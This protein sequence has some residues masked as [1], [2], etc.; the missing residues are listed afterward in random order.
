MS[1]IFTEPLV[2]TSVVLFGGQP[3]N[4][5]WLVGGGVGGGVHPTASFISFGETS[6]QLA[7]LYFHSHRTIESLK[8]KPFFSALLSFE[9]I[10]VPVGF[11]F[12]KKEGANFGFV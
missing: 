11:G 10:F 4:S 9:C 12:K 8:P 3:G 6:K 5:H 2:E 1:S 7:Q